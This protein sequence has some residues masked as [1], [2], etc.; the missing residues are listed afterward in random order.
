MRL[1]RPFR[2]PPCAF[3]AAVAVAL[4]IAPRA[5]AQPTLPTSDAPTTAAPPAKTSPSP[6][7]KPK[8]KRKP[9]PK[10]AT[11]PLERASE[12]IGPAITDVREAALDPSFGFVGEYEGSVQPTGSWR[13]TTPAALHVN[14]IGADGLTGVYLPGR[15]PGHVAAADNG[16]QLRGRRFGR[17]AALTGG[18][19]DIVLRSPGPEA[20]AEV[21]TID[22]DVIGTL[23]KVER[24]SPTLGMAPPPGAIRLFDGQSTE[25]FAGGSITPEG[26][27]AAGT[28]TAE[29]WD[30]FRLHVEFRL[31]YK[32]NAVGQHRGNSGVYLQSRYELQVL[33]SFG[34]VPAFND[35]GSLY[36]TLRPERIAA[37]PPLQWQTYDIDFRS[38]QFDAL[39]RKTQPA[40]LRVWLNGVPVHSGVA[41]PS[42][43]GAGQPEA[44]FPLPTK[45]QDHRNPV[46]F[47]NIWLLPRGTAAAFGPPASAGTVPP[48]PVA[49]PMAM[50][51]VLD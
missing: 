31:P 16:E 36:R 22:G 23:R 51:P 34:F 7:S 9:K 10:K 41:V 47:R 24:P 18:A 48:V 28:E 14:A 4:L 15:L 17:T 3:A 13:S 49:P 42:K 44:D 20:T 2:V 35:I 12:D 11:D 45:F 46:V 27:L 1:C 32:P 6:A 40:R 38:P 8:S 30:D 39:G 29:P 21:R 5:D 50:K 33:D 43:T 19:Y 26:W 25:R 37:R